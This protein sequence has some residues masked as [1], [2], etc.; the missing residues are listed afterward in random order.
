MLGDSLVD[1]L[2]KPLV[3]RRVLFHFFG[4]GF[5][6]PRGDGIGLA[7]VTVYGIDFFFK[8]VDSEHI[9][10]CDKLN[11]HIGADIFID[12]ITDLFL[13][14]RIIYRLAIALLHCRA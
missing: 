14:R 11:Y 13:V 10:R 8:L 12:H 1:H 3:E 7:G 6:H 9:H 4:D 2:G 5:F